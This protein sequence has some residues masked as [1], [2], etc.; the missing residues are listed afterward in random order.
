VRSTKVIDEDNPKVQ[1]T[2]GAKHKDVYLWVFDATKK[3]VYIDQMGKF[4]IQ[5]SWGNKY[6]M[7]AVEMDKNYYDAEPMQTRETKS[8]VTAY[9]AIYEWWKSTGVICPNWH[10]LDNEAPDDFKDLIHANNCK[11]ESTPPDQHKKILPNKQF[12]HSRVI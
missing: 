8:L 2:P 3:S 7:V 4:P 6:I 10:M 12:K 5:P 9:Q 11:V 1:Q